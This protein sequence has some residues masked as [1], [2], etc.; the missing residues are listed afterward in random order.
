MKRY[1]GSLHHKFKDNDYIAYAENMP[2]V[3]II[4]DDKFCSGVPVSESAILTI[5]H[6]IEY[7]NNIQ[8][9]YNDLLLGIRNI[10]YHKK[11]DLAII[12]LK[13]LI[14]CNDIAY[15]EDV[16]LI[17]KVC[18]IGGYGVKHENGKRN[19]LDLV[20]RGGQNQIIWE[21]DSYFECCM[22]DMNSVD[23]EFIPTIGDSGGPVFIDNKL[24]G[25]NKYVK[26]TDGLADSSY[27]DISGHIKLRKYVSWIQARL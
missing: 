27:G 10:T 3:K 4:A 11:E 19:N 26:S 24:V 14:N 7:Q 18:S 21:T 22:D 2:I 9:F 13:D 15:Y 6:A 23:L 16:P 20:K 5:K 17:G 1:G 25:L 12:N 8:I